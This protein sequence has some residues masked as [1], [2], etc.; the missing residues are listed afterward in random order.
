MNNPR[1]ETLY[2]KDRVGQH[3]AVWV[4]H[5]SGLWRLSRFL[6][7]LCN[8]TVLPPNS[9]KESLVCHL[10]TN[11]Y[12]FC[13]PVGHHSSSDQQLIHSFI[14]IISI[15]PLQVH[16]NSEAIPTQHGCCAG[17]SRRNAKGNCELRTFPLPISAVE[18]D[19]SEPSL[20]PFSIEDWQ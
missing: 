10:A 6:S 15:A 2:T 20:H 3:S 18:S 17:V 19:P 9:S 5:I 11:S 12:P 7:F 16:C 4:L 13:S 14:L 8:K 1:P